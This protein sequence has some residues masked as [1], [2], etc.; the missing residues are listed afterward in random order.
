M[1]RNVAEIINAYVTWDDLGVAD[2]LQ[3][4]L[5]VNFDPTKMC[6]YCLR[7]VNG[8]MAIASRGNVRS[9]F[10]KCRRFDGCV[11]C[12][13]C[14]AATLHTIA[15]AVEH[16]TGVPPCPKC[17]AVLF[18]TAHKFHDRAADIV[19]EAAARVRDRERDLRCIDLFGAVAGVTAF[20]RRACGKPLNEQQVLDILRVALD[21]VGLTECDLYVNRFFDRLDETMEFGERLEDE[22]SSAPGLVSV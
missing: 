4:M 3:N 11:V 15:N 9:I 18:M 6:G 12:A 22:H 8:E 14:G 13:V 21:A 7:Q 10:E 19:P 17:G 20:V 16:A 2:H 1:N 5:G